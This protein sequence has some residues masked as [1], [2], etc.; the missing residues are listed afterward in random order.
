MVGGG[1]GGGEGTCYPNAR[2]LVRFTT[3]AVLLLAKRYVAS[4]FNTL[5][6]RV[7]GHVRRRRNGG[8][9]AARRPCDAHL[10]NAF[11]ET[12]A[13]TDVSTACIGKLCVYIYSC[14]A[15]RRA[16]VYTIF[17]GRANGSPLIF[18]G[19]SATNCPC[20]LKQRSETK[21]SCRRK[22]RSTVCVRV[23]LYPRR[24]RTTRDIIRARVRRTNER[25][26]ATIRLVRGRN[27]VDDAQALRYSRRR[28]PFGNK[29][30][31]GFTDKRSSSKPSTTWYVPQI[32]RQ[33]RTA[34][35]VAEKT[36]FETFGTLFT[37]V[38]LKMLYL[39]PLFVCPWIV[40]FSFYFAQFPCDK[41]IVLNSP[42][43]KYG[44]EKNYTLNHRNT[45]ETIL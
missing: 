22:N 5:L 38:S 18:R 9:D 29:N 27:P 8:G 11:A 32:V 3:A 15:E 35:G 21:P 2:G 43:I 17:Y 28:I 34:S 31:Y 30:K 6:S 44:M 10:V 45:F 24:R 23:I 12:G 37:R 19:Q 25:T 13:R 39:L 16:R 7:R 4:A 14:A 36:R 42:R 40:Y 26:Y 20:P 41:K 1:G 33:N